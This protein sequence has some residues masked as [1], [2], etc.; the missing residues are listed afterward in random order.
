[1]ATNMQQRS[2]SRGNPW[3]WAVWG[4]AAGLLL[5]PAIA[6]HLGADGVH[7]T[8]S[9]FTVMGLLLGSCC[10][11]YDVATRMSGNTAYRLGFAIAILLGLLLV[12]INLAVGII[13][14]EGHPA[15]LV[16]AGVL[17]V[18]AVGA[19]LDRLRAAGMARAMMATGIAQLLAGGFAW[20]LGSMEGGIL[21]AIFAALWFASAA[22]FRR[23]A[24]Q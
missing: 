10:T 22:L 6:M 15:N 12:W 3:R 1:M 2:A 5:L 14:G 20:A 8:A 17:L 18:G 9:D 24:L 4:T 21:S 19:L 16:F 13:G 7:W 23:A 11:A